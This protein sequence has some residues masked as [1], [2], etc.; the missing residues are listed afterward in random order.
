MDIG[1]KEE[2]SLTP[3][4]NFKIPGQGVYA[5]PFLLDI[6]LDTTAGVFWH[7]NGESSSVDWS[8]PTLQYAM[9]GNINYR[10]QQSSTYDA[11]FLGGSGFYY[12]LIQ[13][14]T[15]L[16]H[17]IHFH[18][19]DMYIMDYG[20]GIGLGF[21][22]RS[23]S[24][25]NITRRDTHTVD[26]GGYLIFAFEGGNPGAWLLRCGLGMHA[27]GGLWKLVLDN[28]VGFVEMM[29]STTSFKDECKAWNVYR[30]SEAGSIQGDSGLRR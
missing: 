13:N 9:D 28:P 4:V 20:V 14:D 8:K 24:Y 3:Y 22:Y 26:P 2:V 15:P 23:A 29:E 18:G 1:C 17:S 21:E 5:Q 11:V 19:H 27:S 16:P 6:T 12:F 25:S 10:N 30:D 7:F